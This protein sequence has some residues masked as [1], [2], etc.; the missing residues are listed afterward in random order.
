MRELK[1]IIERAVYCDTT[2]EL[3]PEDIGLL[4][5][6][7]FQAIGGN[8]NDKVKSF[9][10]QSPADAL[11]TAKSNRAQAARSLGLPYHQ[12]RHLLKKLRLDEES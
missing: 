12:L 5:D 11:R 3:T 1:N 2:N 7:R 8:F 6:H 4:G 10:R 9:E